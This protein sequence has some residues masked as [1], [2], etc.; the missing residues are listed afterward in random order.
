[1]KL[2]VT[3][4]MTAS[5]LHVLLLICVFVSLYPINITNKHYFHILY[6]ISFPLYYFLSFTLPHI[7]HTILQSYTQNNR[8]IWNSFCKSKIW[9]ERESVRMPNSRKLSDRMKTMKSDFIL[10]LTWQNLNM[11]KIFQ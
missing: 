4:H 6:I 1:M 8:Y 5:L 3:M 10:E 11:D 9:Q 2:C 7:L